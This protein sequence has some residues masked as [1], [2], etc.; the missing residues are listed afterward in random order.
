MTSK[1]FVCSLTAAASC[2]VIVTQQ[3]WAGFS[4]KDLAAWL[5]LNHLTIC[6]RFL[7]HCHTSDADKNFYCVIPG[8]YLIGRVSWWNILQHGPRLWGLVADTRFL[9][10]MCLS[11][12]VTCSALPL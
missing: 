9:N 1:S 6:S 10:V 2:F 7:R 12:S 11:K 5:P 8:L 4:W 3:V